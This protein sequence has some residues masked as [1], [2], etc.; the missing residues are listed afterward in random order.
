M[1]KYTR[2]KC[3]AGSNPE[4][5]LGKYDI[6]QRSCKVRMLRS[7]QEQ[8]A[9]SIETQHHDNDIETC[10]AKAFMRLWAAG[11]GGLSGRARRCD[12]SSSSSASGGGGL[13]A[14]AC[15]AVV[16]ARWWLVSPWFRLGGGSVASLA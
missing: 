16:L 6:V 8:T 1:D 3:S 12:S 14:A 5:S 9:V 2:F 10:L 13:S 15:L 7:E 11:S 4:V